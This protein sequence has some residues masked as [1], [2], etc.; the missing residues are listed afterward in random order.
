MTEYARGHPPA[1][2]RDAHKRRSDLEQGFNRLSSGGVS[3]PAATPLS[4]VVLPGAGS[5]L[6]ASPV[7]WRWSIMVSVCFT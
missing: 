5:S 1:F 4:V 7:W 6:G 2:D 3:P